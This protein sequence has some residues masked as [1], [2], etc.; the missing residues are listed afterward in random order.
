MRFA[1]IPFKPINADYLESVFSGH[2]GLSG[3]LHT[4]V[5]KREE[6]IGAV[7]RGYVSLAFR[8]EGDGDG[9]DNGGVSSSPTVSDGDVARPRGPSGGDAALLA[10]CSC[11]SALLQ[12][13]D[14]PILAFQQ[15]L[16]TR[17]ICNLLKPL[18]P[19]T[20]TSFRADCS[21]ISALLQSRDSPTLAFQQLLLTCPSCN[22]LKPLI[23]A[24]S[25]SFRADC[26]CIS[27]LLQPRDSPILAFQQL[28]IP[29]SKDN[30]GEKIKLVLVDEDDD[31]DD[32][33]FQDAPKKVRGYTT[34]AQTWKM[35][36][37]QRIVVRFNKFGKPV[38]D[39]ANELAQF[40][41]SLVRIS[42]HVSI[43]YPDWR[44]VPTQNKEDMYSLV[45]SKFVFLPNETNEIKKW[46][47][48][49]MG[50]KWRAWKGSLKARLYDPSLTVDEIVGQQVKNDKRVCQ[51][52]FKELATRRFTPKFQGKK[53]VL[54]TDFS[55]LGDI[56][57]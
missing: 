7:I 28:L 2:S 29:L 55:N 22:L 24:T 11:I 53:D 37:T 31:E 50:K 12:P 13:R 48:Y 18:I 36:S 57:I 34:K 21:C 27:A 43:E 26:S 42:D 20:S 9:D 54:V 47:L 52:Q 1:S 16:L 38:G 44:K 30:K 51:T 14:S 15:L 49:S 56:A 10:D 39:E 6:D 32:E 23:L 41:G 5:S 4:T 46:I 33:S 25:T 8:C 19:A 45:K 40:L 35:D 3:L 17:P